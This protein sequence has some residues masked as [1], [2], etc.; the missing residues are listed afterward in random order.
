MLICTSFNL[1]EQARRG[2]PME[3]NAKDDE[4]D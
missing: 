4:E 2:P 1:S 3:K